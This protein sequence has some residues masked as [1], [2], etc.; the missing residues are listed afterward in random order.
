MKKVI[1]YGVF[2]TNSSSSHSI[3]VKK[4]DLKAKWREEKDIPWEEKEIRSAVEKM[5]FVWGIV[6]A[7]EFEILRCE[8]QNVEDIDDE[9]E[10]AEYLEYVESKKQ[11]LID[12]R[13][14]LIRECKK[15]QDF[16]ENEVR[17]LMIEGEEYPYDHILCCRYFNE[18]CLND[19]T[20][21]FDLGRLYKE[22]GLNKH[23]NS[24]EEFA[25][26]LFDERIYFL[27]KEGFY[28][29]FWHIEKYVY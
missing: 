12:R 6:I 16:D 2:E 7:D 19:C 11:D 8:L 13:E 29:G 21:C 4:R 10:R 26:A 1:R 14:A 25:Q 22:L 17:A 9:I 20:C 15:V 3:T 27:T 28:G 23:K 5:L 24:I 18:D